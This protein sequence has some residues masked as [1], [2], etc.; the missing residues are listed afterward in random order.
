MGDSKSCPTKRS[1]RVRCEGHRRRP[2][3]KWHVQFSVQIRLRKRDQ[4]I[5]A[6]C[7]SNMRETVGPVFEDSDA[8][9]SQQNACV[10]GAIWEVQGTARTLGHACPEHHRVK[11][12]LTHTVRIYTIEYAA[13]LLNRS[14]RAAKDNQTAHEIRWGKPCRQKLP[15]FGEAVMYTQIAATMGHRNLLCIG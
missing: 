12:P 13:Q 4:N 15:P 9:E 8:V 5:E 2:A 7:S 1:R 10:E 14:Q 6:A 3:T 11:L